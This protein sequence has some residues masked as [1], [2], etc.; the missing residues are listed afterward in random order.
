MTGHANLTAIHKQK[1]SS[2]Q[3]AGFSHA[4]YIVRNTE[5]TKELLSRS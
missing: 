5:G 3:K 4:T 2:S 1:I